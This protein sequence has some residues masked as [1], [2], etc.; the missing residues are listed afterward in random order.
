MDELMTELYYDHIES[1]IGTVVI[2]C[3]P[4]AMHSLHF[5]DRK[6][7]AANGATRKRDPLGYSARIKAYFDGDLAALDEIAV[8]PSGTPFQQRVWKV[9]RTIP[10]GRTE[11]YGRIAGQ[12][13]QP[14]ASRAVG[15][16]NG[17]NPI[18]LVIPCHRVIGTNG[19][20]T[21][22]GGGLDRKRWLLDHE[23]G[24]G[25]QPATDC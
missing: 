17:Q 4:D 8:N 9:L 24:E 14:T 20:L 10:V 23:R 19:K 22:Y 18:S 16:A 25:W 6:P 3:D 5:V 12:I 2:V 15:L 13:G 7:D 21:G 11:T 1:P